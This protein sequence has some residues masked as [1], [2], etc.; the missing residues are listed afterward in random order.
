[1]S[2][3]RETH[4]D[5][6]SRE[7]ET[8]LGGGHLKFTCTNKK[9]LHETKI[10]KS[11]MMPGLS[12]AGKPC[13]P[14]AV[15]TARGV[16]AFMAAGI[17]ESNANQVLLGMDMPPLN[18]NVWAAHGETFAAATKT[19]LDRLILENIEKEKAATLLYEG[20]SCLT[21]DG[22]VK[23]KVMTDGSWQKRYGRNSLYGIGAMYGYYTGLVVFADDR[24]ARCQVCL[25]AASRGV[26]VA[27]DHNDKCTNTWSEGE[28]ASLMERDIALAG[29]NFLYQHD[30]V[31]ATLICDGDTKT[32]QHIR[33]K[34]PRAVADVI[35][36][37]LDLN[38]VEKNVGTKLRDL[39][40]GLSS[41]ECEYLQK[42]F[43]RGVKESRRK[44]PA[45]GVIPGSEEEKRCVQFLQE[46]VRATPGHL[47]NK[48]AHVGCMEDCPM[49][50]ANLAIYNLQHVPH[51]LGAWS[52]P[53]PDDI[54]YK[55]VLQIFMDY[56]TYD[57][58]AKLIYDC[59]TNPCEGVNSM[60]WDKMGKTHFAPTSATAHM[61]MAQLHKND[62]QGA[63]TL[64]V[65]KTMG[66]ASSSPET[67]KKLIKM[68][69]ARRK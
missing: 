61:R 23:I 32:V 54:K 49:K 67:Q 10:N 20:E 21:S 60:T 4:T 25:T 11:K 58:A 8:R 57:M 47:F 19:N 43:C 37:W 44:H 52:D 59:T 27:A 15:N 34:G 9:C 39:R 28:A 53:G 30:C 63:A 17:A 13:A 29:V 18:T 31:V 2:W 24:C 5:C 51:G 3:L 36:V 42:G 62:G 65:M 14:K 16:A 45:N 12:A 48:D 40:V 6:F 50:A 1:M 38:H 41:G 26:E 7:C 69:E 55:A 64:E 35:D 22:K 68:D 33:D 46:E 66:V 56:T